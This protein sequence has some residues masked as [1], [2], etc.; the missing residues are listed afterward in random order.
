MNVWTNIYTRFIQ[1]TFFSQKLKKKKIQPKL[2]FPRV[3]RSCIVLKKKKLA[4]FSQFKKKMDMER[5]RLC[6]LKPTVSKPPCIV[7]PQYCILLY[8]CRKPWQTENTAV[9]VAQ[10]CLTLCDSM[11]CSPQGSSVHAIL[12]AR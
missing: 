11:D 2:S 5:I 6:P 12:T 7:W 9:E 1:L 8:G 4:S 10:S 3:L